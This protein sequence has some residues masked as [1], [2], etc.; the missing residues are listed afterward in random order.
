MQPNGAVE[1]TAFNVATLNQKMKEL[2]E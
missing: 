1:V 2:Q